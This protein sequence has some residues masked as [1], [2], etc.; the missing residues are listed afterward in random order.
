VFTHLYNTMSSTQRSRH[1]AATQAVNR[2]L[3][4]VEEVLEAGDPAEIGD[5]H[6][7]L[8][9]QRDELTATAVELGDEQLNA[10]AE[11]QVTVDK[12]RRLNRRRRELERGTAAGGASPLAPSEEGDDDGGVNVLPLNFALPPAECGLSPGWTFQQPT[13]T[14]TVYFGRRRPLQAAADELAEFQQFLPLIH[15]V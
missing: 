9:A 12:F 1:L 11:L 8:Q 14:A 10:I 3:A 7:Q 4:D 5:L 13:A 2:S 6:K 15:H